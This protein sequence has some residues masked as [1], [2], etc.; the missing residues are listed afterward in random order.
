MTRNTKKQDH[1][2][3]NVLDFDILSQAHPALYRKEE[4]HLEFRIKN[5]RQNSG[6]DSQ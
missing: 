3:E 5:T 1:G 4:Q 6:G 2:L